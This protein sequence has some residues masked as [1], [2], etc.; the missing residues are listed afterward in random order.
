MPKYLL[1]KVGVGA[2]IFLA[3]VSGAMGIC[4]VF[5]QS[6]ATQAGE[7]L[8]IARVLLSQAQNRTDL[9]LSER[10]DLH[11]K[12]LSAKLKALSY[13]PHDALLWKDIAETTQVLSA[14]RGSSDARTRTALDISAQ[15]NPRLKPEIE[16]YVSR[17]VRDKEK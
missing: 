13:T 6:P 9:S 8:A 15:L 4:L 11:A 2:L 1:N 12:A 5:L 14:A 17:Y 10:E 16:R 3:F 7:N